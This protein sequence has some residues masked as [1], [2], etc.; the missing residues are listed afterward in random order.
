MKA[1]EGT[2]GYRPPGY[3][4]AGMGPGRGLVTL[5]ATK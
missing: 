2:G 5:L 1:L 4:L 3:F